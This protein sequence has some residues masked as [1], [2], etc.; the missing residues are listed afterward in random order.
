MITGG[1]PLRPPPPSDPGP[2][3][4][5]AGEVDANTQFKPQKTN[6]VLTTLFSLSTLICYIY[7]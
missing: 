1:Q 7:Y 2:E 6:G 4:A 3:A 5:P